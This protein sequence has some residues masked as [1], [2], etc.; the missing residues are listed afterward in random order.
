M[1]FLLVFHIILG[2]EYGHNGTCSRIDQKALS[3]NVL[4]NNIQCY[5]KLHYISFCKRT[6]KWNI[7]LH[8]CQKIS[9]LWIYRGELGH[10]FLSIAYILNE[11]VLLV[12]FWQKCIH[13][14]CKL[15]QKSPYSYS[16]CFSK[17]LRIQRVE[18][19]LSFIRNLVK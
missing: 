15:L 3:R 17:E 2:L 1:A 6:G 4:D 11:V 16:T 9:K 5:P 12:Y 8:I 13:R 14:S 10:I 19:I 18:I 7:I